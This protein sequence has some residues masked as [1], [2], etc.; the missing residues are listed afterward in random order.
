MPV[1]ISFRCML[2]MAYF[3][4]TRV[5]PHSIHGMAGCRSRD[6]GRRS[7]AACVIHQ[8]TVVLTSVRYE[9]VSQR[10]RYLEGCHSMQ[11]SPYPAEQR[12]V[13][14]RGRRRHWCVNVM[15]RRRWQRIAHVKQCILSNK[16]RTKIEVGFRSYTNLQK[17]ISVW[18]KKR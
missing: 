2:V 17:Q 15:A 14:V 10:A 16:N 11:S 1:G 9:K 8:A 6:Y 18:P 5:S 3:V 13:F 7:D 4:L 12:N